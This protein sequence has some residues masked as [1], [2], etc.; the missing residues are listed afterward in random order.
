MREIN[1]QSPSLNRRRFLQVSATAAGGVLVSLYLHLPT[2]AQTDNQ[3][4]TTSFQPNAFVNV[5]P[6]GKIVIQVNRLEFGQGVSTSLPMILADE[7]DA[8]W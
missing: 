8:D 3:S 5:R 4:Q 1:S 7:M 6:D 2:G